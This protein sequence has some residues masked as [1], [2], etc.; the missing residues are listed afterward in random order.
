[1]RLIRRANI[2]D[3]C[4]SAFLLVPPVRS[5]SRRAVQAADAAAAAAIQSRGTATSVASRATLGVH[6]SRDCPQVGHAIAGGCR[7][8]P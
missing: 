4:N 5:E 8:A 3:V 2:R 7:R 1:M 6:S